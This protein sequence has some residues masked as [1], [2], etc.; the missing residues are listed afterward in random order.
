M[1]TASWL[2][3][4]LRETRLGGIKRGENEGI[5][6]ESM[7]WRCVRGGKMKCNLLLTSGDWALRPANMQTSWAWPSIRRPQMI[8][9]LYRRR[10]RSVPSNMKGKSEVRVQTTSSCWPPLPCTIQSYTY[11]WPSVYTVYDANKSEKQHQWYCGVL[12]LQCKKHEH[13]H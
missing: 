7:W 1:L 8:T 2:I 12:N 5:E 9:N 10:L 11:T 3:S 13:A 4:M 6:I